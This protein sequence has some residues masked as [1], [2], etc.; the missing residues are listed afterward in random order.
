M[1]RRNLLEEES[2]EGIDGGPDAGGARLI[3]VGVTKGLGEK[4]HEVIGARRSVHMAVRA[5]SALL[6]DSVSLKFSHGCLVHVW[7]NIT[8]PFTLR[9]DKA[10]QRDFGLRLSFHMSVV[11]AF[12]KEGHCH[13]L[14]ISRELQRFE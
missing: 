2:E 9:T 4:K 6:R 10:A 1:V 14:S 11:Q 5:R 13:V 7:C 12:A 3:M 8:V